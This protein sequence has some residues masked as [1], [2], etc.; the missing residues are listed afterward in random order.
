[1]VRRETE[2]GP[3]ATDGKGEDLDLGPVAGPGTTGDV[4]VPLIDP[5]QET[6]RI[7]GTKTETAAEA[8]KKREKRK[9]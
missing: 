8:A 4:E 6:E 9:M 5:C 7:Q 1:V 3:E 2:A